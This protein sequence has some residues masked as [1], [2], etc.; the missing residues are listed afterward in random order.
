MSARALVNRLLLVLAFASLD[1]RAAISVQDDSGRTITLSSPARRIV[2]LTPHATELIFAAGAGTQLV[3]VSDYSDY[4]EQAKKL[5]SIGGP[6]AP[7]TERIVAL[8]PDLIIAW[9]SGNSAALIARLRSL[10]IPVFESEPRDFEAIASNIERLAQLTGTDA[11]GKQAATAFRHRLK[12]IEQSYSRRPVARVF[13][14]IWREPVMTI[15]GRHMISKALHL[16]GGVNIFASLPQLAPAIGVESVLQANPEV[17]ITDKIGNASDAGWR[18]FPGLTAAARGNVF[19]IHPDLTSRPGPRILDG[20]E[21]LCEY[22][23]AAR[24]KRP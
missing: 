14:Q 16:C 9:S 11:A 5:P 12:Q 22:L 23:D 20:T 3:A 6:A 19:T 7:D 13:Y 21:L 24:K 4:P 17:I 8:K 10:R 15:N 1:S 2:T 18:R